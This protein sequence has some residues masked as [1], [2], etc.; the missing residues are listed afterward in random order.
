MEGG[1]SNVEQFHEMSEE[2][3]DNNLA[4]VKAKEVFE[5]MIHLN[6]E[7]MLEQLKNTRIDEPSVV[8]KVLKLIDAMDKNK[9]L[10][11]QTNSQIIYQ[12]IGRLMDWTGKKIN[13]YQVKELIAVGGMS[14][15]YR[16]ERFSAQVQKPVAIKVMQS[17]K[18]NA[19]I[20][21]LFKQEQQALSILDHPNI[22]AFHHGDQ[23]EEGIYYLVMEYISKAKTLDTYIIENNC[24]VKTIVKLIKQVADAITYAHSHLIIH[25]DLKSSNILVDQHGTAKVIDFGIA[26]LNDKPNPN[27]QKIYTPNIASPE[28][29][30]GGRITSSTD[31]FSLSATL[32]DLL[33][34]GNPLPEFDPK[35][36]QETDDKEYIE[37]VLKESNIDTDLKRI[38]ANGL[39]TQLDNRY[40]TM[41]ALAS[42]LDAWLKH[43]PISLLNHK[44]G[45]RILKGFK[46]NPMGSFALSLLATAVIFGT[47]LV[48]YYALNARKQ[49]ENS[50]VTLHF[51]RDVLSQSDPSKGNASDI[52]IKNALQKT[53]TQQKHIL[54]KNPE[55]KLSIM[56]HLA[57]IYIAQ[58]M[59]YEASE[60]ASEIHTLLL[61]SEGPEALIT[62][63][64]Q[65]TLAEQLSSAGNY[66]KAIEISRE[67]LNQLDETITEHANIK[68]SA[69]LNIANIHVATKDFKTRQS[70]IQGVMNFI[71]KG[72][73]SDH[74]LISEAWLMM[75][76]S[77]E[78]FDD[79]LMRTNYQKALYH[80]EISSGKKHPDYAKILNSYA[81]SLTKRGHYTQSEPLFLESIELARDYDDRGMLYGRNLL[82]YAPMLFRANQRDKA[83]KVLQQSL[84]VIEASGHLFTQMIAYE[85]SYRFNK[86]MLDFSSA[87]EA[88]ISSTEKAQILFKPGDYPYFKN[89]MFLA[90]S[91]VILNQF[92]LAKKI[93]GL[94]LKE[95]VELEAQYIY[96]TQFRLGLIAWL[97]GDSGII[98]QHQILSQYL[99]DLTDISSP[100]FL[101]RLLEKYPNNFK[102]HANQFNTSTNEHTLL[103]DLLN[104][105]KNVLDNNKCQLPENIKSKTDLVVVKVILKL[106]EGESNIIQ[107]DIFKAVS[108]ACLICLQSDVL[109]QIES[110]INQ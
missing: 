46:R 8:K 10:F 27:Y 40:K 6:K 109:E 73:V 33:I 92:D 44:L 26:A 88:S 65:K 59:S 60:M 103:L 100:D 90:E 22:V 95:P 36:Y 57:E 31:I 105:D 23:T 37:K 63:E 12:N 99:T 54:A 48:S 83:Q 72:L 28:Q 79:D 18:D 3:K 29:I 50:R 93:L 96:N 15:I 53:L 56:T 25:K 2:I 47:V 102:N 89:I 30:K 97:T 14:S 62:L 20:V 110:I 52:T 49:A 70:H 19:S 69:L 5:S 84:T 86:Q 34:E 13:N 75:A 38:I 55:T 68:L 39:Q 7:D 101:L 24:H 66:P 42:D 77:A 106:C 9:T 41:D 104:S 74:Q 16:A 61:A 108:A 58:G 85:T 32:L 43:K 1:S 45:Y 98:K 35:T 17:N 91:L 87:L 11:N 64:W 67:L 21:A 4:W 78:Q 71:D 94:L 82:Q 81:V 76:I 107:T 51:L 80:I